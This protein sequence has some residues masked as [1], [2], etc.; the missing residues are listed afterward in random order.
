MN[1]PVSA[2]DLSSDYVGIF[3]VGVEEDMRVIMLVAIVDVHERAGFSF[4][5]LGLA[6]DVLTG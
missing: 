4:K 5:E 6:C 1:D 3:L 2:E